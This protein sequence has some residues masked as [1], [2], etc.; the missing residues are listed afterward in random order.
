MYLLAEIKVRNFCR[1]KILLINFVINLFLTFRLGKE[2]IVHRRQ[3]YCYSP[4]ENYDQQTNW[5]GDQP[6]DG[7]TNQPPNWRKLGSIR[8]WHFQWQEH[9]YSYL[10]CWSR[11]G[12][13]WRRISAGGRT[14]AG[15][16]FRSRSTK[17]YICIFRFERQNDSS[18]DDFDSCP[19]G[20]G[21]R[22][23]VWFDSSTGFSC[24]FLQLFLQ[25]LLF[26]VLMLPTLPSCLPNIIIH[27]QPPLCWL[28]QEE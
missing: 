19:R 4:S 18:V 16:G 1:L 24:C 6:T 3:N 17:I 10:C 25:Q 8:K 13:A 15:L 9:I 21:S 20:I 23:L 22:L 14:D 27:V 7:L 11:A 2:E 12:P 28:L 26:L 5:R